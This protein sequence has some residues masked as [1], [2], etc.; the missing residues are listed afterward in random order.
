ML[1]KHPCE[2]Y[3]IAKFTPNIIQNSCLVR[4]FVTKEL[5]SKKIG[6]SV[7][8]QS[9]IMSRCEQVC[10][11]LFLPWGSTQYFVN[12]FLKYMSVGYLSYLINYF[13]LSIRL[14]HRRDGK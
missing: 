8:Y 9:L 3:G 13:T 10:L 1:F 5:E 11:S 6:S 12:L 14:F 2:T 7:S 4:L